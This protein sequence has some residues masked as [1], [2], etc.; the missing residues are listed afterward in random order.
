MANWKSIDVGSAGFWVGATI[1]CLILAGAL[2]VASGLYSVAASRGHFAVTRWL[3]EFGMRRS[4]AMHSL[5]IRSPALDDP[6]KIRLGAG[7]FYGGCAPCHGAPGERGTPIAYQMLPPPPSLS[8]A[9]PTWSNEELFWIVRNGIKYTGMPAWVALDRDDEVWAVVAFLRALPGMS[10]SDY[11]TLTRSYAGQEHRTA[12]ELAQFGHGSK[13]ITVCARCHGAESLPPVS[14]LVPVLAGQTA[15]YLATALRHYAKGVRPSGI[16]QPV[17]A[18][19]GDDAISALAGYYA[20]LPPVQADGPSPALRQQVQ[21]GQKVA[22][23]GIP[24]KGVPPCLVCH[25]AGAASFPKLAGQHA[26]YTVAQLQLWRRGLRT[27]TTQGAIMA[28]IARRLTE[29]QARDV[30]AFFESVGGN[31]SV[32]GQPSK[33][34]KDEPAP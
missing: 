4:V 13:A 32:T 2:W 10:V 26:P 3:L 19:L 21:R 16:M 7:H 24:E 5:L 18:E 9:A 23:A 29:Q 33:P 8:H 17:A 1:L 25:A 34:L 27:S 28:P 15:E 12:R 14:R 30:A 22:V 31:S 11:R 20:K 6:D